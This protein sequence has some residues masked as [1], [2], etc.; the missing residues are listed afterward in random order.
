MVVILEEME[1][2]RRRRESRNRKIEEA[3]NVC[4]RDLV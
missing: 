4:L 3:M 1:G 2:R